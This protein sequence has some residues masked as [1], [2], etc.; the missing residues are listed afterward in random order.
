MKKYAILITILLFNF[1]SYSQIKFRAY[2]YHDDSENLFEI[3]NECDII[4]TD[5]YW[6]K[7]IIVTENNDET[8]YKYE[9]ADISHP[10]FFFFFLETK[11]RVKYDFVVHYIN[12]LDKYNDE[13]CVLVY[14]L[15][16]IKSKKSVYLIKIQKSLHR[17]IIYKA[18]LIQGG[19]PE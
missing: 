12:V 11:A 6:K 15:K 13:K 3:E 19:Y 10:M 2:K 17:S 18:E 16:D 4:I 14:K 7:Q 8:V 5:D 9:S 1:I